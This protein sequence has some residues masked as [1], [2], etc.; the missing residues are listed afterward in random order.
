M[1]AT[2]A[3]LARAAPL[4]YFEVRRV[5]TDRTHRQTFRA[6]DRHR[7]CW[8]RKM[9]LHLRLRHAPRRPRSQFTKRQIKVLHLLEQRTEQ[10]QAPDRSD[11]QAVRSMD[12][13]RLCGRPSRKVVMCLHLRRAPRRHWKE[14]TKRHDKVLQML[15]ARLAQG[16]P[17]ETWHV[18]I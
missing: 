14:L 16:S 5:Q 7:P 1:K 4:S 17:H 8:R 18:A 2:R 6:M 15:A 11:W 9:V 12:R 13:H 3:S 10:R